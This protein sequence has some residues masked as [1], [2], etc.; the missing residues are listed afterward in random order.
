MGEI[1]TIGNVYVNTTVDST[2]K[3]HQYKAG[4]KMV[5][6]GNPDGRQCLGSSVPY[7][8]GAWNVMEALV[9]GSDS[10]VHTV[11]GVVVFRCWKMRWSEKDDANDMANMLSSG[12]IGLQSEGAGVAYRDYM[13]MELDPATGKP[14]NAKPTIAEAFPP[15][16]RGNLLRAERRDGGWAIRYSIPAAVLAGGNAAKLVILGLDGRRLDEMK[17]PGV[18][19]EVY[20]SGA[21]GNHGSAG[22]AGAPVV[23]RETVSGA[24][25]L[26]VP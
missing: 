19:G 10:A 22:A 25:A 9:R 6:H 15:L 20:W 2:K 17:L 11:N 5:A 14:V 4:G 13:F 24:S 16:E 23:L 12:S 1:W 18:S 8:D 21:A 3:Q 26:C 7:V